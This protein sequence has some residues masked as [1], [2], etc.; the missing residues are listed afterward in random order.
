M[1]RVKPEEVYSYGWTL[2]EVF[3]GFVRTTLPDGTTLDA[4]PVD[5]EEH[6]AR[7]KALGYASLWDMCKEHDPT[8]ALLAYAIGL[9]ESPALRQTAE[10][11]ETELAGLEECAVLAIQAFRNGCRREGLL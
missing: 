1:G 8:H 7:A 11:R 10:G 6:Q 2:V 3:D 9:T 5:G 4:H